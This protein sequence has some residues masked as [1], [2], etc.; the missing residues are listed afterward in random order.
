[1]SRL[2][3]ALAPALLLAAAAPALA[4]SPS[5][6]S[7]VPR[8]AQRGAELTITLYGRRLEDP[9]GLILHEPGLLVLKVEAVPA[10]KGQDVR[11]ARVRLRVAPDAPLGEHRLRLRTGSGVSEL[12]TFWVSALPE[13]EE[14]EPNGELARAQEVPL[15]VTINGRCTREDL[16]LYR[17]QGKQGQRV[18]A[19]VVAMRLGYGFFDA[20]LAILDE[21]RFELAK[22]DDAPFAGQDPVASCVLPRDGVYYVQVREAAYRGN[23]DARYRLHLGTFPRPIA[24]LPAGGQPGEQLS[25]QLLGEAAGVSSQTLTL[26]ARAGELAFFPRRGDA[27]APTPLPLLVSPLPGVVEVEP[28]QGRERG[29]RIQAPAAVHGVLS[30]PGDEDFYVFPATKGQSFLLRLRARELGSALDGV[31]DI[32]DHGGPHRVGNDDANGRPDPVL[33]FRAPETKD[34]DLRVRDFLGRGG[35][36]FAY[37]LE[38]EPQGP[39]LSLTVNRLGRAGNQERQAAAVPQGGRFALLLRVNRQGFDAPLDLSVAGLGSGVVAHLPQAPQGAPVVPVVFEAHPQAPLD[40]ALVAVEARPAGGKPD[41]VGALEHTVELTIGPPNQSVYTTTTVDRLAVA[42][43]RPA[44]FAL[45]LVQP[46]TPL[47]QGGQ[48]ALKL[49][50]QRAPGFD[51]PVRVELI[52]D[53]PG[54]R[55]RRNVEVPKGRDEVEIQLDANGRAALGRWPLVAIGH[56]GGLWTSSLPVELEVAPPYLSLAFERAAGVLGGE[57]ELYCKVEVRTPFEGEARVRLYQLPDH[58]KS[59]DLTLTKDTKELRFPVRIADKGRAGRFPGIFA[60]VLV[61]QGQDTIAHNTA[62]TELRIDPPPPPKP[63]KPAAAAA[64]QPQPKPQPQPPQPPAKK[65]LTRL[66]Q[67]R[68][69]YRQAKQEEGP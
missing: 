9:L 59:A 36:E 68:E 4:A 50:V 8:G 15:E 42:V 30:Q 52:Y 60:Q 54:V 45:T 46:R 65:P 23:G 25:I 3:R 28:N 44:P 19:E 27:V 34:Y 64:P 55:S 40:G 24:A 6:G 32:W 37:R 63:P 47:V 48:A 51:G 21:G 22:S 13:V 10:K 2:V 16:D 56:V 18:V 67:L 20:S 14:K 12:R 1:M 66:E 57:T 29:Q 43:T 31:V 69:E 11:A 33:R 5:V 58:A 17:F 26:P 41:L 53:P 49:Q 62:A 61:P 35:P 7:I 39:G 38:L